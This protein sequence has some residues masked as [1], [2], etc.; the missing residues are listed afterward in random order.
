MERFFVSQKNAESVVI[1]GVRLLREF[2]PE[3]VV[4]SVAGGTVTVS[5]GKL[6]LA[7]FDE[8]EIEVAGKIRDVT[9]DKRG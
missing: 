5:G 2:S 6:F 9:T 3:Q 4:V 8:N 7:R 1:G